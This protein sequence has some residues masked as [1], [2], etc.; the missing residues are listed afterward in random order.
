[1]AGVVR[2]ALF[3]KVHPQVMFCTIIDKLAAK[4]I[5]VKEAGPS[6]CAVGS[7]AQLVIEEAGVVA[8]VR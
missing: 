4:L 8:K 1:M 3:G 5:A 2:G 7:E 6:E